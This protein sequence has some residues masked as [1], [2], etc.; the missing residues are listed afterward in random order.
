MHYEI[1]FMESLKKVVTNMLDQGYHIVIQ[2]KFMG[3]LVTSLILLNIVSILLLITMGYL[4]IIQWNFLYYMIAAA[5]PFAYIITYSIIYYEG[6]VRLPNRFQLFFCFMLGLLLTICLRPQIYLSPQIISAFLI[7]VIWHLIKINKSFIKPLLGT[8]II[9]F[10]GY[11]AI[12]NLNYVALNFVINRH[13]Y[14]HIFL[15]ID[16]YLYSI[17]YGHAINQIGMYPL[18]GSNFLFSIFETSYVLIFPEVFV[19]AI[20]LLINGGKLIQ[21]ITVLFCCYIFGLLIFILFPSL[22]PFITYPETFQLAYRNTLTYSS[23]RMLESGYKAIK[24]G[25]QFNTIGYFVAMPSLHVAIAIVTQWFMTISK[26]H[27]WLFLPINCL[28]IVS[29]FF[30]GYHFLIDVPTGILLALVVIFSIHYLEKLTVKPPS[31]GCR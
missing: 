15:K 6:L 26:P 9:Y 11:N 13:L 23:M 16:L 17:L 10:I 7:V 3:I 12:W 1:R 8:M 27:F 24:N 19:V 18:V 5:C 20:I 2:S 25:V 30:L 4:P 21:Y 28:I 14:D 22:G 29:T 31:R